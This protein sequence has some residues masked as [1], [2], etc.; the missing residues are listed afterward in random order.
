MSSLYFQRIP[1][2]FC[3]GKGGGYAE[4]DICGL[5]CGESSHS[6]T[7]G[8]LLK[9]VFSLGSD[10]RL[11]NWGLQLS[12][13]QGKISKVYSV[14]RVEV[15]VWNLEATTK[16]YNGLESTVVYIRPGAA[17]QATWITIPQYTNILNAGNYQS[18]IRGLSEGNDV[19]IYNFISSL[20][21]T[22]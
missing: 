17:N 3:S 9:A 18:R 19:C 6:A 14:Y 11:Y 2:L 21:C 5:Y 1:L 7:I 10:P 20:T 16:E 4:R 22:Y 12:R 15:S 13:R 8:E